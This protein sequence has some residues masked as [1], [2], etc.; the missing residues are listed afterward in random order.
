MTSARPAALALCILILAAAPVSLADERRMLDIPSAQGA[1]DSSRFLDERAHYAGTPADRYVATWMRDRLAEA[2]FEAR[3]EPFQAEVYSPLVL[4]L[5]LTEP[6]RF[7]F[8]LAE[9]PIPGDPDGTRSDAGTPFNAGSGNGV[10]L[11]HV[12]DA[13]HGLDADYAALTARGI[14]VR[15]AIALIRYGKQFRGILARR[16]QS[17]GAA[18]VIFFSD[19]A[20]EPRGARYPDGPNRPLG[21][22]QRG[23]LGLPALAIPVLSVSDLNAE[24]LLSDMR[25]GVTASTVRLEVRLQRKVETL[26]NVV[27]TL[28]GDDPSQSVVLGAHRDA[29]VYGV[30]DDGSGISILIEAA[31][32]L[33]YMHRAGWHPQRSIVIA[34]FDGEEIGEAGSA[35]YVRVHQRELGDGAIAYFNTD[36]GTTGQ[37]FY[38]SAVAGLVP[39]VLAATRVVRDP[40][41]ERDT[42][43]DRWQAQKGGTRVEAPGGGS[44]H[45]A[46]LFDLG[47]P[48]LEV[49]FA[50]AFGVDHSGFDDIAYARRFA[51]TGFVNHRAVAQTL[52]LLAMRFADAPVLP[53][54]FSSYA[55][56]MRTALAR[57]AGTRSPAQ[58]AAA[59]A[60]VQR[61]APVAAAFDARP[62]PARNAD[63]LA[64]ARALDRI[65][66]GLDGY[67]AVAFPELAQAAAGIDAV[68]ARLR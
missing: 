20:D 24:R 49:G 25:G 15:G 38:A 21:S 45:E 62:D 5:R 16:A 44:D 64:A 56:S 50:G 23:S 57:L 1:L 52:A 63:A 32:A 37:T 68:T 42:L 22:V 39:S 43:F 7:S 29:W 8:D 30:T 53:Y 55:S 58:L 27:G 33:G 48:V 6:R 34:G 67:D 36:E 11:A 9:V 13:G 18:G 28:V 59:N 60:A 17:D 4:S 2:G 47:I 51:D 35:T 14:G 41:T 66:Y 65:A 40:H 46:F 26:W 31:R 12:V 19:P 61:F 54:S 10:A 3:I